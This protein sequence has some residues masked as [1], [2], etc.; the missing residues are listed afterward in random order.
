MEEQAFV[1]ETDQLRPGVPLVRARGRVDLAAAA[2]LASVVHQ[3][4]DRSPWAV[5]LD[6]SAVLEL[7]AG[8]V[9]PLVDLAYRA[10]T[11]DIGLY[12]VTAGGA[13]DQVLGGGQV[14]GL[15]DIHH[16]IDSADRAMGGRT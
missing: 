5:V 2:A 12:V 1:V 3:C 16:S 7:R 9:E 10:G 6:L 13:V 15:F 8:A 4:L 11:G 14:D